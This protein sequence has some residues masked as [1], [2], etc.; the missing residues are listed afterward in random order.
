M[1]CAS[2]GVKSDVAWRIEEE[3]ALTHLKVFIPQHVSLR[4]LGAQSTSL[5]LCAFYRERGSLDLTPSI[6]LT[7]IA[8]ELARRFL[9]NS[10]RRFLASQWSL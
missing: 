2:Y 1:G 5:F 6:H 8:M 4:L 7:S 3:E 10:S 9:E